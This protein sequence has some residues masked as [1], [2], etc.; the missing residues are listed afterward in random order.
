MAV[1]AAPVFVLSCHRSGSTLL[2]FALD[3]H[4]EIYSPPQLFLGALANDWLAFLTGLSGIVYE[5]G[6]VGSPLLQPAVAETRQLIAERMSCHTARAGKRVWCEKTPDNLI[7]LQLIDTLFPESRYLCLYR[8]CL[9]V[10]RSGIEASEVLPALQPFLYWSRGHL[11]TALVRYWT[12]WNGML[13]R[14]EAAHPERCCRIYY[15][16][17]VAE[18]AT[19]L[20]AVFRFLGLEWDES[21]IESI[22]STPHDRGAEDQKVRT[23]TSIHQD[24]VGRGADLPLDSVPEKALTDMQALLAEL[25]Y[26]PSPGAPPRQDGGRAAARSAGAGGVEWL[27]EKRLRDLLAARPRLASAIG[28][29]YRFVVSGEGGGSWVVDA[30]RGPAAVFAGTGPAACVIHISAA[31]LMALAARRLVPV[32]AIREGRLRLEGTLDQQSLQ[33]LLDLL[34]SPAP[35]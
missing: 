19:T 25:G 4:P 29:S 2:R 31:D 12:D 8:H 10:V 30:N 9:D 21:L 7:H 14:F 6:E 22:F 13:R 11:I 35:S 18:P 23:A 1:S 32:A 28:M 15:E 24:S 16:R 3:T 5:K 20:G 17:L 34:W 26:P 33:S 27:F